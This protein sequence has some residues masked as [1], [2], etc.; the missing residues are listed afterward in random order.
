VVWDYRLLLV[1]TVGG[2]WDI[3]QGTRYVFVGVE[4]LGFGD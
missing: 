4:G 2:V 1:H 3:L